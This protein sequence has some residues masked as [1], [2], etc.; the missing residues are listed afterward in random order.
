[1]Q[2]FGLKGGII[3]VGKI[4]DKKIVPLTLEILGA[5][6]TL[7]KEM[8][9]SVSVILSGSVCSSDLA[10]LQ[11]FGA[12]EIICLEH[13]KLRNGCEQYHLEALRSCLVQKEP[14]VILVGADSSGRVLASQLAFELDTEIVTDAHSLYYNRTLD[15]VIIRR[16]APDGKR[17]NEFRIE[18]S[19][20]MAS[21]RQGICQ[22][23]VSQ[24][25]TSG[26]LCKIY[27]DCLDHS[28]AEKQIQ[29]KSI[30]KEHQNDR[31]IEDA[32]IIISG[33]RGIKGEEGFALL[34]LLAEKLGGQTGCTRPC[35]DAGWM[36]LSR[37][38]GQSGKTVHPKLY[39]ACGISGAVQHMAGVQAE[40]L[41][42]VNS[43]P[44]AAIF[45]YC[46]YGFVGDAVKI[47]EKIL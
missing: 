36:P 23:A 14:D 13:P 31:R 46:D 9:C 32:S 42:A 44:D 37:Q 33:G 28:S 16:P 47:I 38:I 15:T 5:G 12:D 24:Q 30:I 2:N 11:C 20:I 18:T 40:T 26:N 3:V 35:V 10:S 6:L 41:I 19:P 27:M 8:G 34:E 29:Y 7:G 17:M 1:M 4:L 43:N 39:I 22:K 25:I 45:R 21:F